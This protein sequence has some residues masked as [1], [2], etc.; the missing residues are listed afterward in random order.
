[1]YDLEDSFS[2]RRY[3]CVVGT[4]SRKYCYEGARITQSEFLPE[5]SHCVTDRPV[6]FR[7]R[8]FPNT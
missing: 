1:M 5:R 4:F 3:I 6:Q 2:D 7:K 8:E